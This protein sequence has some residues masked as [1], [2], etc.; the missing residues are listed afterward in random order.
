M[1]HKISLRPVRKGD[2]GFLR[3]VYASTRADEMKLTGWTKDQ[4]DA[5]LT[6]QFDAQDKHYREHYGNSQFDLILVDGKK[7]GRLYVDRRDDEIRIVDIALLHEYRRGGIGTR[8]LDRLAG[9][10]QKDRQNLGHSRGTKQPCPG[11]LRKAG[12]SKKRHSWGLSPDGMEPE[13]LT[14]WIGRKNR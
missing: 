3:Q 6:F 13:H 10:G 2:E 1:N 11:T 4:V 14:H 9:R 12:L 5:F 8:L 7:A